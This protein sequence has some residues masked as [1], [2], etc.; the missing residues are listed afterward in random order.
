M[1]PDWRNRRSNETDVRC[2]GGERPHSDDE[3][4]E[5][6]SDRHRRY[7]LRVLDDVEGV[8]NVEELARRV[9][10]AE[11]NRTPESV[12]EAV[13]E[14]FL[15]KFHHSDLPKFDAANVVEYDPRSGDVVPG[16]RRDR[17]L[18]LL[19]EVES[20]ETRES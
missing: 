13:R 9:A 16:D 18:A 1:T 12:P 4:Y 3:L 2:D 11:T 14:Y 8:T 19:E 7:L 15:T 10:A 20:D 6:L 5:L 17:L